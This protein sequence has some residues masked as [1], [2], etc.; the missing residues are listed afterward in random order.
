MNA[1]WVNICE[2]EPTVGKKVQ[3]LVVK[4]SD[5]DGYDIDYETAMLTD[6]G[7][8]FIGHPQYTRV[9]AWL[10]ADGNLSR[11]KLSNVPKNAIRF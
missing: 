3:V 9:V 6:S 7:W 1:H 5:V 10:E 2:R 11:L 4:Q 8:R